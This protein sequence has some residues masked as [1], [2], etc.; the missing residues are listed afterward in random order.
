MTL[1]T[2]K[3]VKKNFGS[4]DSTQDCGHGTMELTTLEDITLA[5][6]NLRPGWK[7]SEHIRP[8]AKTDYCEATHQ[9]YVLSGRLMIAME[10]G[11][12]MEIGPGDFAVIAPGHDAWVVGDEPFVA[13]DFSPAMKH[14]AQS[15]ECHT[16]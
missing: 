8:M 16:D 4:P 15:Q 10:D 1:A 7:W 5:R 6:L 12:K 13:L 9:Q 3:S 14:Y 11:T 2:M